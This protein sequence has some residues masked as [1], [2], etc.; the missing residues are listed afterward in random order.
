MK[1]KIA[2]DRIGQLVDKVDALNRRVDRLLKH[3]KLVEYTTRPVHSETKIMT[4]KQYDAK[5]AKEQSD[6]RGLAQFM[7]AQGQNI[8]NSLRNIK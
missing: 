4:Q 1:D 5:M 2:R 6:M 7:N 8:G 3:L